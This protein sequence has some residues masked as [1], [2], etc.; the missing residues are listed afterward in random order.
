MYPL[1]HT[2][3]ATSSCSSPG[4]PVATGASQH[5][6]TGAHGVPT[7]RTLLGLHTS[8]SLHLSMHLTTWNA[9]L[10]AF[11][12]PGL[13]PGDSWAPRPFQVFLVLFL[14]C[15]LTHSYTMDH[16]DTDHNHHPGQRNPGKA[17]GR[18][19]SCRGHQRVTGN[20]GCKAQGRTDC[21]KNKESNGCETVGH[22]KEGH[23]S[24]S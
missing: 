13:Y 24:Q 20:R 23:R 19:G 3:Q 2:C 6:S 21:M 9:T 14:H 18:L 11:T 1:P 12:L 7:C 8:P 16:S 22:I 15:L 5:P 17:R 4:V 10:G